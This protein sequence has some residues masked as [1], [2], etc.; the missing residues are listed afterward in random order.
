MI[1][2]MVGGGRSPRLLP[3]NDA[4]LDVPVVIP[5][6]TD[7]HRLHGR[8]RVEI[9]PLVP[10]LSQRLSM[11]SFHCRTGESPSDAV[12]AGRGIAP[13]DDVVHVDS[14]RLIVGA[15]APRGSDQ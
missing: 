9:I 3:P 5:D 12:D 6:I 10:K 7:W 13:N 15:E 2:K 4:R 11:I 1:V 14:E 8:E